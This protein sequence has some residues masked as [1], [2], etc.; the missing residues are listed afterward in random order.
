MIA[1]EENNRE[2]SSVG[3]ITRRKQN[4]EK[5]EQD[6]IEY[7]KLAFTRGNSYRSN[8]PRPK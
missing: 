3:M 1:L 6:L 4:K 8:M 2:E 5:Q 7:A